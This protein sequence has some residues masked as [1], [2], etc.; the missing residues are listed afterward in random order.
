MRIWCAVLA[1]T[2]LVATPAAAQFDSGQIAGFVRDSTNA[3]LP[4]ATATARNERNGDQRVTVAN[5]SGYYVFPDLPVGSYTV[6][7]ELQGFKKFIQT[8]VRLS[9]AA[10]EQRQEDRI[11][12]VQG[13]Q[14]S[15]QR[16][17]RTRHEQDRPAPGSARGQ[18]HVLTMSITRRACLAGRHHDVIALTG[19]RCSARSPAAPDPAVK[20]PTFAK[21]NCSI[22][23][24][25][26]T[27]RRETT[28]RILSSRT[29]RCAGS[30]IVALTKERT[31]NPP[32]I[33]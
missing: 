26:P 15:E 9:S 29:R 13:Q 12:P 6:T 14:Q 28:R 4:G 32:V 2:L 18:I 27:R 22:W 5:G 20:V 1:C 10:L 24:D 11:A 25:A 30:E 23:R 19:W 3:A 31:R 21:S 7:V 16:F 33:S 8:E 17:V